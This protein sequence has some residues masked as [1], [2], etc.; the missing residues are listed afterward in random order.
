MPFCA[1]ELPV[2]IRWD[3]PDRHI[4]LCIQSLEPHSSE[5]TFSIDSQLVG[6][7]E[8]SE[9][10]V[11]QGRYHGLLASTG[12]SRSCL[13]YGAV[14]DEVEEQVSTTTD[15][16]DVN[17]IH[18]DSIVE[19]CGL[20]QLWLFEVGVVD[21]HEDMSRTSA[22][23]RHEQQP[24]M[25]R[26]W[27]IGGPKLHAVDD[28]DLCASSVAPG[29]PRSVRPNRE[30]ICPGSQLALATSCPHHPVVVVGCSAF[31]RLPAAHSPPDSKM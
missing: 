17:D 3:A 30:R 26:P 23:E 27:P 31:S 9:P 12:Q 20:V 6:W 14:V 28:Q 19:T 22:C 4:Q 16:L 1:T 11:D 10:T 8:V 18:A 15:V 24:L 29:V 21:S 5:G 25:L 7:S 13:I 2:T